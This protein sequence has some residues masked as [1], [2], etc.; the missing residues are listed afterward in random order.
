MISRHLLSPV[1]FL[2]SF[3]FIF[4]YASSPFYFVLSIY[5]SSRFR[6]SFAPFPTLPSLF[7]RYLN[8]LFCSLSGIFPSKR[9]KKKNTLLYL[10]PQ[11]LG[12]GVGFIEHSDQ[13][14]KSRACWTVI[15]TIIPQNDTRYATIVVKFNKWWQA[16][17]WFLRFANIL[18]D[19]RSKCP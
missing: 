5:K 17:A 12:Q 10:C 4:L 9:K 18:F 14:N 13:R 16:I 7:F 3:V 11:Q 8:G 6:L 1:I 15:M 2:L 19:V